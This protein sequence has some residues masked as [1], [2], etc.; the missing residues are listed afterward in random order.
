MT[1]KNKAVS[2]YPIYG[3][4]MVGL[5]ASVLVFAPAMGWAVSSGELFNKLDPDIAR[6]KM[7]EVLRPSL[8][9]HFISFNM[10]FITFEMNYWDAARGVVKPEVT[11][12]M[13]A[14]PGA[15]YRYPGGLIANAFDWEGSVGDFAQRRPQRTVDWS[16]GAPVRFGPKEYFSFLS[17]VGGQSWYVLNLL[18]WDAQTLYKELPS[19]DM[20]ASN[21]R[22]AVFRRAHD[23]TADIPRYYHLGNEL[24]R[25]EYEWPTDKYIQR[26]LDSMAAVRQ[27]DPGAQFVPFLRDFDWHYRGRSGTS[28][29]KDFARDVLTA[30]PNVKD[31]SLQIYYDRPSEEGKTFDVQWRV[32]LIKKIIADT[33][34]IR[35]KPYRVWITE[36]AK[37]NPQKA[38]L[39]YRLETTSGITGA[40]ASADFLI[41]VTQLPEVQGVFWHAL[42]GGVWW[43]LFRMNAGHIEPTP[44]YWAFRLLRENMR[45]SVLKTETV[46]PNQS[47]YEGGYDVRSV[48]LRDTDGT[49]TIWAINR[50]SIPTALS[51]AL[52][53][54]ANR[55][56]NVRHGFV[57]AKTPGGGLETE[58]DVIRKST[59]NPIEQTI[60]ASGQ[61]QFQLPAQSVSTIRVERM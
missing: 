14:F 7:G 13:R 53:E 8:P 4:L 21:G 40:V 38:P 20:A 10:N 60:P 15:I 54:L 43:D 37:Q 35:G 46:G 61:L 30:L 31:F 2:R 22:L 36:N 27:A 29:A 42:G 1:T 23:H 51:I 3:P 57:A 28:P 26:S 56:V 17:Q 6:M 47:R 11:E 25:S 39:P 19:A 18:G 24:D 44:V 52:A 58:M 59:D 48:I 5:C 55:K 12:A 34:A 9:N 33:T 49:L 32:G 16:E 50:A 41:A 45:G